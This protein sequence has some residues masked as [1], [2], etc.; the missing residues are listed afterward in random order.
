M[1]PNEEACEDY[2]FLLRW[3][4]GFAC[5]KKCGA[6]SKDYY[7][8]RRK[9]RAKHVEA[10]NDQPY[11]R[12][13][14][15]VECKV[16]GTHVYL[17]AETIMHKAHTPLLT[18]FHGAFLVTTLTPG[19]SAVQFQ[20]QLGL[21]RNETAFTI[22]HKIRA[23]MVDPDRGLLEGEVEVDETYVGGVQHGGKGGRSLEGRAL[24]VGAVEVRKKVE[25]GAR[26]A[27][28]LRL[29]TIESA[30]AKHLIPFV[31]DDVA[32]G[33][34]ILTDGWNGYDGLFKFGYKHRPEVEGTPQRASKI[35]PLIH[36]EFA[37]LK[38]WLQGTHHGRV[39]PRH[40]QAYLNEFVFRHNRRFWAFSAFQTVLR[41]GMGTASPTYDKLYAAAGTGHDVHPAEAPRD[42]GRQPDSGRGDGGKR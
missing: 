9:S 27:G 17:T 5:P 36:R 32:K 6:G 13:P 25:D 41:L 35:L 30:S 42:R 7:L 19:I 34:V 26:Y 33:T 37:N 31:V 15:V 22:L 4:D 23:A 40:L 18:W 2:L 29:R 14:R 10:T 24:V 39:T 12:G 1:F 3:P 28:R 16:C 20:R 8:I 21:S 38:T 11:R